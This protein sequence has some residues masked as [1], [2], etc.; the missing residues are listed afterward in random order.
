MLDLLP[1]GSYVLD[2]G[3]V[4]G[5]PADIEI[6]KKHKVTGVD[7]SQA[8]IDLARQKVPDGHFIQGDAACVDFPS[9]S[10]LMPWYLFTPWSISR[11]KNMEVS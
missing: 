3:C 1:P 7:I 8:Q 4:S 2:L 6:S 5:D 9:A 10:F 11:E